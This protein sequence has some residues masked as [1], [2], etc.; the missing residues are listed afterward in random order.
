MSRF[1]FYTG[2]YKIRSAKDL[3]EPFITYHLTMNRTFCF[4]VATIAIVISPSLSLAQTVEEQVRS[5]KEKVVPALVVVNMDLTVSVET[6]TGGEPPSRSD[7]AQTL[8]VTVMENGL[9]AVSN[10]AI[11][12]SIGLAGNEA[13]YGEDT[14][15]ITAAKT[16][17]DKVTISY[18]DTTVLPGKVISQDLDADIAFILPDAVSAKKAG[19]TFAFVDL[20]NAA[21]AAEPDSVVGFFRSSSVYGFMPLTALGKIQGVFRGD[22]TFYVTTANNTAGMPILTPEGKTLGIT[23]VRMIDSEPTGILTTLGASSIKVLADLAMDKA[24]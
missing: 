7:I 23:V 10:S 2:I 9:I 1:C 6:S 4:L 15:L 11:D 12:P 22:R 24:K 3:Y 14:V 5:L 18:G 20:A 8:G 13:R 16:T 17:Y 19:K 21:D